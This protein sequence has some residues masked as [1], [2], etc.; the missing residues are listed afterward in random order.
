MEHATKSNAIVT[1]LF[2]SNVKD[3]LM[4]EM[5]VDK[6][7]KKQTWA[8]KRAFLNSNTRENNN[9]YGCATSETLFGSQPIA[10]LF[11]ESTIM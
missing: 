6:D 3:R 10:D 4:E 9:V 8:E 1:S 5:N 2:P 11:P 7:A